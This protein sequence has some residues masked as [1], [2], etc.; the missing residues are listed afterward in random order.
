MRGVSV[1]RIA[2]LGLQA[3]L[4]TQVYIPR[5]VPSAAKYPTRTIANVTVVDSE[6]V[7]EA[8]VYAR[9]H[10]SDFVWAHVV[11]GWRKY[12]LQPFLTPV[13][14]S[15]SPSLKARSDSQDATITAVM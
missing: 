2:L 4:S 8:Q 13:T 1:F 5:T 14:A 15:P 12:Y 9:K 3:S 6:L 10:S 7:R 11:R